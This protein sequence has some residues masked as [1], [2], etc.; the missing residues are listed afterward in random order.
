V[1]T[2][3]YLNRVNA[4]NTSLVTYKST[5][6]AQSTDATVCKQLA[7]VKSGSKNASPLASESVSTDPYEVL[8][9]L[10][11]TD[12]LQN[13]ADFSGATFSFR[14]GAQESSSNANAFFKMHA[15]VT[16]GDTDTVRGSLLT[17]THASEMSTLLVVIGVDGA[18]LSAVSAQ[19]GDRI[20]LEIG[21]RFQNTS[22]TNFSV[23]LAF[24]GTDIDMNTIGTTTP[25]TTGGTAWFELSNDL[26][27]GTPIPTPSADTG[28][29]FF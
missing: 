27:F 29:F 24:G 28:G 4:A 3:L 6:N 8:N 9:Q 22:T 7:T 12:T 18:S 23:S 16:V 21:P 26:T 11:Y 20:V 17:Y 5:W 19:P 14:I 10:F 2:R 1:A 25:T 15:W 13:A